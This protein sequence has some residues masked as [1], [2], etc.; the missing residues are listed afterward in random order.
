MIPYDFTHVEFKKQNEQ[1][2]KKKKKQTLE[3]EEQI[4]G[5]QWGWDDIDKGDQEYT[6]CDEHWVMYRNAE[7]LYCMR[8][9]NITLYVINNKKFCWK[10]KHLFSTH[11]M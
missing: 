4:R 3:Y 8:E 6:Y 10:Q 7:S 11:S 5:C 9:T 1:T 2:K